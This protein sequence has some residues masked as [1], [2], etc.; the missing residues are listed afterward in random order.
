VLVLGA[1]LFARLWREAAAAAAVVAVLG[2]AVLPRAFPDQ[3]TGPVDGGVRLDVLT[4]NVKL[5]EADVAAIAG[6]VRAGEVDLLSIQELT[7]GAADGL[8]AEGIDGLLPHQELSPTETGSSGAG[9]YSRHPLDR[10][11]DV[12]GGVSRQ[13]H[14]VADVPG[15]GRVEFVAVHPFPPTARSAGRWREGLEGLPRATEGRLRI[16]PGDFNATFDHA[17]FRDLVASGYVDA[18]AARGEGLEMTWPAGRK[19]PP[20][21]AIDHVLVDERIHVAAA[22]IHTLPG[23]DHRAVLARLELPPG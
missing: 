13:V 19:F 5:G 15:V 7:H 16:L 20:Q 18:A 17:P 1:A 8:R 2:A 4:S 9:L 10:L 11:P 14:A 3:P 22:G 23:T 6:L 21:V 12:P